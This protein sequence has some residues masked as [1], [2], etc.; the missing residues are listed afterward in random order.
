MEPLAALESALLSD[1][2]GTIF[3]SVAQ[4][5]MRDELRAEF[6]AD[7]EEYSHRASAIHREFL[8]KLDDAIVDAAEGIGLSGNGAL[9]LLTKDEV[10]GAANDRTTLAEVLIGATN[11]EAF[12]RMMA[13][14]DPLTAADVHFFILSSCFATM[15]KRGRS[16]RRRRRRGHRKDRGERS[17]GKK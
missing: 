16:R 7:G 2:Q 11:F 3:R 5:C 17:E 4:F 13:K 8:A 14:E 15:G 12:A 6:R 9:D 1:S 10:S